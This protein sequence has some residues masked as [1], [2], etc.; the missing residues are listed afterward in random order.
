[1][2]FLK[3]VGNVFMDNF[4][5][6]LINTTK[7]RNWPIVRQFRRIVF[8]KNGCNVSLFPNDWDFTFF[9]REIKEVR[10]LR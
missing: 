7:K 6:H 5:K 10:L 4:F 8:F 3:K 9:K 2:I 1:M